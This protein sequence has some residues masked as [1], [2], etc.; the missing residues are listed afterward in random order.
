MKLYIGDSIKRLRFKK[1]VTQ[2]A[3]ADYLGVSR[4]AI[5][6]WENNTVY[7]DTELLP[8]IAQFFDVSLEELLGCKTKEA[9]AENRARI[10]VNEAFTLFSLPEEQFMKQR[11][12]LLSELREL[13]HRFP[14]NWCI[15]DHICEALFSTKREN[16][17]RSPTVS[18]AC[19]MVS[20][21]L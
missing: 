3:L 13:E 21:T 4:Q 5:S 2:E 14:H 19:R 9:A 17:D 8:E 6:R 10:L 15:K 20:S 16:V 18:Y 12:K 7:P 1:N 11:E